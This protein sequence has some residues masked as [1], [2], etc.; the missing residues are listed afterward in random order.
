MVRIYAGAVVLEPT[1]HISAWQLVYVARLH[2]YGRAQW[3]SHGFTH[4]SLQ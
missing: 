1:P 4:I 2:V 3:R